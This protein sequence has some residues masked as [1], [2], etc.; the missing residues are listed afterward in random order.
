MVESA[1]AVFLSWMFLGEVVDAY[2]IIGA[3]MIFAAILLMA[4]SE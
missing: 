4:R 3:L 2:V 1:F